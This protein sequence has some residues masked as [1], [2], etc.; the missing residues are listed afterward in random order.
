MAP[1]RTNTRKGWLLT[2]PLILATVVGLWLI[3]RQP[4]SLEALSHAATTSDR[5][6]VSEPKVELAEVD[7]RASIEVEAPAPAPPEVVAPTSEPHEPDVINFE[8]VGSPP[9]DPVQTGPAALDLQ[10]V[11]AATDQAVAS[12]VELWRIDAPDNEH[13]TAGDQLQDQ[14]QVPV[15]GWLFTKLPEGRYRI[16]CHSQV[17]GEEAPETDVLAPLTSLRLALQLPREFRIRLD[18]RDRFGV[19]VPS[20]SL[21]TAGWES[22][23]AQDEWRSERGLKSGAGVAI[24]MRGS[25]MGGRRWKSVSPQP[26]EGFDLGQFHEADRGSHRRE[27]REYKTPD[28]CRVRVRIPPR[29]ASDLDLVVVA[30]STSEVEPLVRVPPG[31]AGQLEVIIVGDTEKRDASLQGSGWDRAPVSMCVS[32]PGLFTFLHAWRAADGE[33]PRILLKARP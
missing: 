10:L 12:Y 5:R 17:W 8:V 18:V 19:Q 29:S 25:R 23:G 14:A 30:L 33:L 21:S 20:L 27:V 7:Q 2:V 6:E 26:P 13:W 9:P 31:W 15:E 32:G 16:V 1:R 11:D 4:V 28:G 22:L 3:L 24:G